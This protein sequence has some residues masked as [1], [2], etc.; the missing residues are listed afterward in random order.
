MQTKQIK[1]SSIEDVKKFVNATLS[2]PYDVDVSSG[3]YVVD[4]KSI[5]GLFSMDLTKPV[6]MTINTDNTD[7]TAAFLAEIK[8]FIA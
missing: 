1:L 3:R 4:A 7:A 8:E 5:M 2:C 6:S